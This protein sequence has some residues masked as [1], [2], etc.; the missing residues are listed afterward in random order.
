[1]PFQITPGFAPPT[2]GHLWTSSPKSAHNLQ[3]LIAFLLHALR[4]MYICVL[5]TELACRRV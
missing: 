3:I 5:S 4:P 2:L 1:M